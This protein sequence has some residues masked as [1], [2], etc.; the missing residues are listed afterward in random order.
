[1]PDEFRRDVKLRSSRINVRR[2]DIGVDRIRR[3][4][5]GGQRA[6]RGRKDFVVHVRLDRLHLA[7][8]ENPFPHQEQPELGHRVALRLCVAG[9]RSLVKLLVVGKRM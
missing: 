9:S 3:S 6:V 7:F 5:L 4:G 8:L 1:M 2:I